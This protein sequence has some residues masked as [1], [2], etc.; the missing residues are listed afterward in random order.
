[1]RIPTS[2]GDK[3]LLEDEPFLSAFSARRARTESEHNPVAFLGKVTRLLQK[4][5]ENYRAVE[6]W[7]KLGFCP[8]DTVI[9]RLRHKTA[10]EPAC[11]IVE[12]FVKFYWYLFCGLDSMG[13][14]R[15]LSLPGY[16]NLS[17]LG[18]DDLGIKMESIEDTCLI[19]REPNDD[20]MSPLTV[21]SDDS[22]LTSRRPS[23]TDISTI[24]AIE[25][26]TSS[27]GAIVSSRLTSPQVLDATD[28]RPPEN[29]SPSVPDDPG[30]LPLAIHTTPNESVLETESDSLVDYRT[31][32]KGCGVLELRPPGRRRRSSPP[33][34]DNGKASTPPSVEP[35]ALSGSY[36]GTQIKPDPSAEETISLDL[37]KAADD[38]DNWLV[39]SPIET[40]PDNAAPESNTQNSLPKLPLKRLPPIWAQSRQEVCESFEWFR[41]Y[42]G[43]VYRNHGTVKGYFLS[44]FS[45]QRDCFAC[46]GKII[47]SHGGGKAE[48]ARVDRGKVITKNAE[49]QRADDSSVSSLLENYQR[50]QPLV[51]LIDDK[52]GL[53][54]FDL[55]SRGVYMAVLGFY[56]II[57][58]WAEYQPSSSNAKGQVVRYKFAFQWCE[59]QDEPWWLEQ[60]MNAGDSLTLNDAIETLAK[61]SFKPEQT[62]IAPVPI[63]TSPLKPENLYFPCSACGK[64]SPHVYQQAMACLHPACHLFWMIP[65]TSDFLPSELDYNPDFLTVID[66]RPIPPSFRGELLPRL[67]DPAPANGV[68]T[69]YAYSRGWHC[70]K[71][72]RLS[73]R[74]TWEHYQCPHCNDTRKIVGNIRPAINLMSIDVSASRKDKAKEIQIDDPAIKRVEPRMFNLFDCPGKVGH[75]HTFELPDGKGKIHRITTNRGPTVEV[76]RIFEAYQQ[77]ASDGTLLFR[78]WPLRSHK[79]RG[80]L[81]TNYFSQNSGETYQYVGGTDNTVPFDRAPPA[82]IQ[83]RNLIE[84]R[85]EEALG[86]PH[87]FNEVLSAAYMEQQKMAFH[88]DSEKGLGPVVAGLSMGSPALMH[89]RRRL[90]YVPDD[91]QRT[92]V[93]TVVLRHG[94]VL[95]MEGSGVQDFYEHTVVPSNFRIAA[96]ARWI[97]PG[98]A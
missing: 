24:P 9:F 49:D 77:Q 54:P 97:A 64:P 12:S 50:G 52:Y 36:S 63:S 28:A 23:I 73:C 75:C 95:V 10:N 2:L 46:D 93:L 26:L 18:F 87:K 5:P 67:L 94:D 69:S 15:Q 45:A 89:F 57:H 1:M 16:Q 61:D 47:I 29:E 8:Q 51:L 68:T 92:N 79:L 85:I 59:G 27:T 22:P 74:S 34:T 33:P 13:F 30:P 76:D 86:F 55:T 40:K 39:L 3:S 43:G 72:G 19:K 7:L 21:L 90:K 42:Q 96:T 31:P 38:L 44:A 48:S 37:M 65:S 88:S 56:R 17:R 91:E 66:P 71:C 14:L 53:F 4:E 81:L 70:R 80:T 35:L 58:A 60:Y 25:N 41:S 11:I 62:I 32:L 98:H 84:K 78:R 82:V 20:P 6:E 83:A